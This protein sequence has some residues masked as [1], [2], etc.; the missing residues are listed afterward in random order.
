MFCNMGKLVLNLYDIGNLNKLSQCSDL[1][2]TFRTPFWVVALTSF[3]HL[4]IVLNSSTNLIM[5][6]VIGTQ[7]RATLF[8]MLP[9]GKKLS[10][11]DVK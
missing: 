10:Q 7:F 1:H 6:A 11:A 9:G 5:F 2:L 4:L 8:R 3:N